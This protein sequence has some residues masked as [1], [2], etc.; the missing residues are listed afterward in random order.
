M[1]PS[2]GDLFATVIFL[3]SIAGFGIVLIIVGQVYGIVTV[4]K[5]LCGSV[6]KLLKQLYALLVKSATN[7][8]TRSQERADSSRAPANEGTTRQD[9]EDRPSATSIED[10]TQGKCL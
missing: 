7:D 3:V 6:V 1:A 10:Y 9:R 8:T 4:A 2:I 5:K